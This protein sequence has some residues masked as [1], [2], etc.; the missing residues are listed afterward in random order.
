M[1]G[2]A[3]LQFGSF[4]ICRAQAAARSEEEWSSEQEDGDAAQG[5]LSI[6]EPCSSDGDAAAFGFPIADVGISSEADRSAAKDPAPLLRTGESEG[7]AAADVDSPA[8]GT[9]PSI[10]SGGS[11]GT[12]RGPIDRG[13]V[14]R[15]SHGDKRRNRRIKAEKLAAK[16]GARCAQY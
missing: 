6:A 4:S 2:A 9:A 1:K 15:A 14:L 12:G 10:G 3:C 16:Q 5:D 13:V 11:T 8:G 7:N